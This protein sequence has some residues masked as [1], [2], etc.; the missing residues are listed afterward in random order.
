VTTTQT[1]Q[2][3]TRTYAIDPAHTTTAF[4]VR[5]MMIAKVRGHFNAVTGSIVL[6]PAG[7]VPASIEATVDV[8]SIDTRE[9]QRD[10]HLKS[11]D[12]LDAEKFPQ[13]TF[14]ST[15]IEGSGDAFRVYGDLTIHGTTR[16]VAFETTFEGAGT[17]PWGNARVGYEATAKISRKDFGLN[18]NQALE[19]GGVLVGDEVRIELSVE[20]T[21]QS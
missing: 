8:A 15:R 5:H 20:A 4:V 11:A 6:G 3:M 18:W 12:F 10:G 13:L 14:R 1:P 21:A 2:S 19:T 9:P 16:E 17:D 7:N